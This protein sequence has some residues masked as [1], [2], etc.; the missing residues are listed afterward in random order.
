MLILCSFTKI[1]VL[2]LVL[3]QIFNFNLF[4]ISAA[5]L[6]KGLFSVFITPVCFYFI[7]MVLFLL[8]FACN[9]L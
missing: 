4:E 6:E 3:V 2:F 7:K 8:F 9:T 1:E 5:I